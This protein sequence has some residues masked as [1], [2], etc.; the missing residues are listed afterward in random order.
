MC[1]SDFLYYG[2]HYV[3]IRFFL[4]IFSTKYMYICSLLLLFFIIS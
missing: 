2:F 3:F 1:Q 4:Y